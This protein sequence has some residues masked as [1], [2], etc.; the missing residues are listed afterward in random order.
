MIVLVDC[1]NFYASCEQVF[2][3]K[4]E[5]KP[6]LILSNNDGCVI[7]RSQKAKEYGV[8]MGDPA[9][10]YKDRPDLQMLS[11]NFTLY[12]D[13]SQRVMQTLTQF[14]PDMEVYSIDEAFLSMNQLSELEAVEMRRIVKKWTGLP[15]SIGAAMTKTLAKAANKIAKKS[16]EGV[17]LLLDP[18]KIQEFLERTPPEDLWGIGSG[19]ATK[20]KR[21]G[22][23]TAAQ[24]RD[25]DDQWL[26]KMVG[27]GGYKTAL[28]LRGI[29][30]FELVDEPEKKQSILCSR[31]FGQ[32][33]EKLEDLL[34]SVASFASRAAEK[35]REQESQASFLSV[36][37]STSPFQEPY[38]SKSCHVQL[39]NATD[40]TPDLIA[41]A[42]EGLEKIFVPGHAYKKAGV[43]LAD[44]TDRSICQFDALTPNPGREKKQKAMQALDQINAR[45]D[46]Q[47]V[48]FAAE[49][50]EQP[51][52][53]LRATAS[54]KYTTSWH[55][56]LVIKN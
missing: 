42:K 54:P 44:L 27:L 24:F 13:M 38:I 49:G 18:K 46:K 31:S 56:I 48:R 21:K 26:K 29:A 22:I 35:L 53:S 3:P 45:Y 28:E 37:L 33:V 1:N 39:P 20:L 9:Y 5:G 10:L 15:I 50:L 40:F 14:S 6:L 43:L 4:L 36:F 12:A 7:A 52:R 55:D 16:K 47:A 25:C 41:A 23:Y 30:C 19:L 8:K 17:C 11:S 34:E 2:N 51:W 32:K